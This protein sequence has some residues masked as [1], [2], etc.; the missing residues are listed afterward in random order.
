M[1][2]SVGKALGTESISGGKAPSWGEVGKMYGSTHGILGNIIGGKIGESI[3][4]AN[5]QEGA[6]G[7]G[8]DFGPEP[9]MPGFESQIDPA[10]GLLK[11]PYQLEYGPEIKADQ[12][13]IEAFRN[14]A[15]Q[16]GPSAWQNLALKQQGLEEKSARENLAQQGASAAAQARSNLAMRGGLSGGAA[17][18]LAMNQARAGMAGQ[19][20]LGAQ[21][22]QARAN[23]ALQDEQMR[24]QFLSQLPQQDLAQANLAMQNRSGQLGVQEKNIAGALSDKQA[25]RQADLSKYQ[26]QMKA[27]SA[28]QAGQAMREAGGSGGGKK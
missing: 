9:T 19:Q 23:L 8:P 26:E 15:L 24:N 3:D 7:I 12:R 2:G 27:Y 16:E 21:G 11:K 28:K 13:G 20:Q 22:A 5:G 14:R 4:K 17:E 25:Q 6:A 10:T 1:G 18:R